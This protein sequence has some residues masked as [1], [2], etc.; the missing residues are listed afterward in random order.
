MADGG[1][2]PTTGY[3]HATVPVWGYGLSADGG[4]NQLTIKRKS[5]VSESY[6][7]TSNV[8]LHPGDTVSISTA[9]GGSVST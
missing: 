2:V 6:V 4:T 7:Y 3:S 9:F 5:N 1:V 8:T